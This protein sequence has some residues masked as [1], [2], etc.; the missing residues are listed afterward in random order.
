MQP[1]PPPK[2]AE[3][4]P[5]FHED[6]DPAVRPLGFTTKKSGSPTWKKKM[7]PASTETM[8]FRIQRHPNAVDP[9]AGG[10]FRIEF[11][12]SFIDRP[13]SGLAGR[14]NFD[15]LLTSDELE[16]VVGYQ[17]QVIK[18][19]RRPPKD[20]IFSYP[21]YLRETYLRNFDPDE[22]FRTGDFWHR[23]LSK[24]HVA[25][26]ARLIAALLPVVLERAQRLSPRNV[27]L[28]SK[29]DLATNPLQPTDSI[30]LK[31]SADN[32]DK[33]PPDPSWRPASRRKRAGLV[34]GICGKPIVSSDIT[35]E[36][37]GYPGIFHFECRLRSM[38]TL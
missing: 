30:V 23:F 6:I 22:T 26:W 15:Q 8:F 5:V 36:R 13:Y 18:S 33:P 9:Y 38:E 27:Y 11:E 12:H 35:V 1:A 2:A 29:I 31:P 14:A 7:Q 37:V 17:K 25:V 21:E 28:G 4:G 16:M 3:T 19:L 24:E 10:R 32:S 34:C 20:W